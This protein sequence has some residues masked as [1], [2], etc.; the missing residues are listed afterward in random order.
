M[1]AFFWGK[2]TPFFFNHVTFLCVFVCLSGRLTALKKY[3]PFHFTKENPPNSFGSSMAQNLNFSNP[4]TVLNCEM[5]TSLCS[6]PLISLKSDFKSCQVLA[7]FCFAVMFL[8]TLGFWAHFVLGVGSKFC[9]LFFP[10]RSSCLFFVGI[11][12][13]WD[14]GLAPGI[15]F[16]GGGASSHALKDLPPQKKAWKWHTYGSCASGNLGFFSQHVEKEES[17]TL[18][19][20]LT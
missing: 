12:G 4:V 20:K 3:V 10:S 7:F 2:K 18:L 13:S 14:P 11:L 8:S 17:F 19:S 1:H 16:F 9:I 6:P 5:L 15:P